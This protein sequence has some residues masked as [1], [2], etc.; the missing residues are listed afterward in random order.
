MAYEKI[1][2]PTGSLYHYTKKDRLEAILRDGRIRR[3]EDQECWFC[4]SLPDT[5]QLMEMTVMREGHRYV[6]V[7]GSLRSY[8]PFVHEDYIILELKPRYQNGE[9]VR[10]NEELPPGAPPEVIALTQEFNLLKKGFRGDLKF[11]PNPQVIE[12]SALLKEQTPD[13]TMTIQL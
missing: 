4:T 10:W 5:L 3:F 12:V 11:Y 2:A 6:D 8:P 9:W 1:E 13:M 7:R